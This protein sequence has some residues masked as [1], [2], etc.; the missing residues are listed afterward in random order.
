MLHIQKVSILL[1]LLI[2]SCTPEENYSKIVYG[3]LIPKGFE[4]NKEAIVSINNT[5]VLLNM[6]VYYDS[7]NN[8]E[9]LSVFK[10]EGSLKYSLEDIKNDN[11]LINYYNIEENSKVKINGE[12]MSLKN[13]NGRILRNDKDSIICSND[14]KMVVIVKR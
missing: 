9:S 7:D 5:S 4:F 13:F 14:K 6:I 8:L 12:S 2:F 10:P 3:T 11:K 1:I